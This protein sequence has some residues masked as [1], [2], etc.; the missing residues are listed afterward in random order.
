ML[1]LL[2]GWVHDK[3]MQLLNKQTLCGLTIL[4]ALTFPSRTIG[5]W[6][7]LPRFGKLIGVSFVDSDSLNFFVS[8]NG[9]LFTSPDAVVWQAT[10]RTFVGIGPANGS[11]LL[12][13]DEKHLWKSIDHGKTWQSILYATDEATH[14]EGFAFSGKMIVVSVSYGPYIRRVLFSDDI[15][16]TWKQKDVTLARDFETYPRVTITASGAIFLSSGGNT[17]TSSDTGD[18]WVKRILPIAITRM[19]AVGNF[20]FGVSSGKLFRSSDGGTWQEMPGI[21]AIDHFVQTHGVFLAHTSSGVFRSAD[22]GQSWSLVAPRLPFYPTSIAS[23]GNVVCAVGGS[24]L[25]RS[26]NGG[27]WVTTGSGLETQTT[28]KYMLS[29]LSVH[30]GKVIVSTS[31]NLGNFVGQ[32]LL[33]LGAD[34]AS[35]DQFFPKDNGAP[36]ADIYRVFMK[37]DVLVCSPA[38]LFKAASVESGWTRLLGGTIPLVGSPWSVFTVFRAPF[39]MI[40]HTSFGTHISRDGGLTWERYSSF[41][42]GGFRCGAVGGQTVYAGTDYGVY[43]TSDNGIQ[44]RRTLTLLGDFPAY[45][46]TIQTTGEKVYAVTSAGFYF[47]ENSGE[48]WNQRPAPDLGIYDLVLRG[49]EIYA[50]TYTGVH[51]S[52]DDGTTWARVGESFTGIFNLAISGGVLYAAT[53]ESVFVYHLGTPDPAPTES[54][55]PT[56]TESPITGIDDPESHFTVSPNPVCSMLQVNSNRW[57]SYALLSITGAILRSG[58]YTGDGISVSDLSPGLYVVRL[59]SD[60]DVSTIVK[61]VVTCPR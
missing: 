59:W 6:V 10:D 34:K 52:M 13:F 7:E 56:P 50:A 33:R 43:K 45:V 21:E 40:A 54:P 9:K 18:T 57:K 1:R 36:I 35:W 16:A 30:E 32:G 25:L 17:Y 53:D 4:F 38:G 55:D 44:W 41:G 19:S 49:N 37:E 28:I 60:N 39:G 5:Q 48:S 11:F 12:R 2:V 24:N 3:L 20:F 29:S 42:E 58:N 22:A 27:L 51:L 15:G 26:V 31:S 46:S 8:V 47:S 14:Y 61:I 23:R